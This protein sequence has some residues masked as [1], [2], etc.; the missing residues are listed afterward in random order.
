MQY[1]KVQ[2]IFYGSFILNELSRLCQQLKKKKGGVKIH[3]NTI[4]KQTCGPQLH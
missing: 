4:K 1:P 2:H 3:V